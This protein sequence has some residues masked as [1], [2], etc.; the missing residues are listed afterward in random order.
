MSYISRVIDFFSN[1]KNRNRE[2]TPKE[3]AKHLFNADVFTK[4]YRPKVTSAMNSA[5][6]KLSEDWHYFAF[7][8]NRNRNYNGCYFVCDDEFIQKAISKDGRTMKLAGKMLDVLEAK[9]SELDKK[10]T[11]FNVDG[12][13]L[14][15]CGNI[16]YRPMKI[17]IDEPN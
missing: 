3:L 13:F 7:K 15:T 5:K 17:V 8:D 16:E 4:G 1:R 12:V 11:D 9:R 14:G 6:D 10:L 2:V